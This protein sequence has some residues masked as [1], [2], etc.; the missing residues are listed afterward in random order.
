[1]TVPCDIL[2]VGAGVLG[3]SA[4]YHLAQRRAGRVILLERAFPGAGGSGQRLACVRRHE[5]DLPLARMARDSL[6]AYERFGEVQ[7]GPSVLH[8]TGLVLVASNDERDS[9]AAIHETLQRELGVEI[10]P[11]SA[12][13][14][15]ELDPNAHLGDRE[16]A[17][18]DREAGVLDAVQIVTSFTEAARRHG[19]DVRQGVEVQRLQINKG[20][21]TGVETNEGIYECGSLVVAAGSWTSGLIRDLPNAPLLHTCRTP[22]ALFRRPPDCAR[23]A[24]IHADRVQ[25]LL[26]Q[27]AG[28]DLLLVAAVTPE[29]TERDASSDPA[30][31]TVSAEW[32]SS[33][34][35]RLCRRYPPL[36]RA[37][38]RGGYRALSVVT[39]NGRPLLDRLP[40][41]DNGWCLTGFGDRDV[42]LAPLAGQVLADLILTGKTELID[43]NAFRLAPPE[44]VVPSAKEKA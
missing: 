31:D 28:G 22:L 10:R 23:R 44:T 26:F 41:V 38:G 39:P 43:L 18:L 5:A 9:L 12:L 2:I 25:G 17:F 19:A 30:G 6:R 37:Y 27:P 13:E 33:A 7:T 1:M 16:V 36:H 15:L 20:K 8:R 3:A 24:V 34:R 42:E 11:V 4:A 40:G 29:E 35:Q 21:I 32:L 14:L